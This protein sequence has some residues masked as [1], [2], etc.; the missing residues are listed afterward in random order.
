MYKGVQQNE[1]E[2]TW[3]WIDFQINIDCGCA[4]EDSGQKHGHLDI[5]CGYVNVWRCTIIWIQG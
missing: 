4:N 3:V 1:F 2:N 5:D